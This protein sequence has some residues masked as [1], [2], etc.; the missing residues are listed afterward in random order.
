MISFVRGGALVLLGF[1]ILVLAGAVSTVFSLGPF[2][3]NLI[4]PMVIFLGVAPDVSIVRGVI[5]S[6]LLGYLLD[7]LT[8]NPMSLETFL[9]VA[10]F[11]VA[12]GA[13][14]RLFLR[15]PAFQV[16]L[17]FLATLVAGGASLAL[18]ALF[19]SQPPFA[20]HTATETLTT[21][22]GPAVATALM[23]PFVFGLAQRVDGMSAGRRDDAGAA[24]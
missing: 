24:A 3:P 2:A 1:V 10:T 16:G 8:G 9:C 11:L 6:F 12:R 5:V 13:G 19:E 7:L 4:L 14:L 17:T 20:V 21:L 22:V 15:G 23:A 18:R